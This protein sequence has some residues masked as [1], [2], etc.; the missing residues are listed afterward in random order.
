MKWD[1]TAPAGGAGAQIAAAAVKLSLNVS[2]IVYNGTGDYTIHFTDPFAT[3]HF[4]TLFAG[5]Q[6][7]GAL[8][9]VAAADLGRADRKRVLFV[10]SGGSPTSGTEFCAMFI[11]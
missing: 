1:G 3:Q 10:D 9:T 11:A 2:K 7:E 5:K 6:S 8:A 4:A